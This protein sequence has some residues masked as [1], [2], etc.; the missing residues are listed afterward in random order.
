MTK[1]NVESDDDDAPPGESTPLILSSSTSGGDKRELLQS[2]RRK[3][4]AK[5]SNRPASQ[6][7]TKLV[8]SLRDAEGGIHLDGGLINDVH[9]VEGLAPLFLNGIGEYDGREHVPYRDA[10]LVKS[11][12]A[13][14]PYCRKARHRSFYLW[15]TNVSSMYACYMVQCLV[16]D[17][18]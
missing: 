6:T 10:T 3:S 4:V 17:A 2:F 7:Q 16:H 8:Q 18:K 14:A 15:W 12:P 13:I 11:V 1:L 5:L 9:P